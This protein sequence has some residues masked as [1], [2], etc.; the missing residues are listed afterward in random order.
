MK[1]LEMNSSR[2]M[3]VSKSERNAGLSFSNL[4]WQ[5]E[6]YLPKKAEYT[7]NSFLEYGGLFLYTTQFYHISVRSYTVFD[8]KKA[9]FYARYGVS[10]TPN[11]LKEERRCNSVTRLR[12]IAIAVLL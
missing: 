7:C 4:S 12:N 11:Y 9:R 3:L 2:L 10:Q 1:E 6:K 8:N 5:P